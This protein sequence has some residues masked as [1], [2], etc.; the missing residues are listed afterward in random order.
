MVFKIDEAR[1]RE[2]AQIEVKAD[3]TIGA[4]G[5]FPAKI[6]CDSQQKDEL[7]IDQFVATAIAEKTTALPIGYEH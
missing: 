5:W 6:P 1:I 7:S 4:G 2:V 3:C